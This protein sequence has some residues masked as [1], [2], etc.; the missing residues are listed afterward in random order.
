MLCVAIGCGDDLQGD[1]RQGGDA[2]IAD[3]TRDAFSTPI[4]GLAPEISAG[5]DRGR[6]VFRFVWAPPQLGRL[7]NHSS[8]SACHGGG[9]RGISSL[10]RGVLGSQAL[11]RVSLAE[12]TP[13]EPGGN[14]A[15]PDLGE[16]LQDH[17]TVGLPEVFLT[18]VWDETSTTYGDGDVE[19]MRV[20]RVNVSSPNGGAVPAM[21][22]SYRQGPAVFGLGLLDAV[23]DDTL[24]S[25]EDPDDHD[26][27]GISGRVNFVWDRERGEMRVGR[28][29][30]KATAAD[31]RHQ[32]AGAFANDLGLTNDLHPEPAGAGDVTSAQLADTVEFVSTLAVPAA[33]PRDPRALIGSG[34]FDRFGCAAC[35]T[36]TL[37]TGEHDIAALSHQRIHP[38]TDLLLHDLG[39]SLSD[40]R[41]D[42]AATGAEWR[43]PALW[44]IG[45]T[46]EVQ[47]GTTYL[48][49]GRARSLAEAI[50]WHGGE[51]ESAR[52]AFRT[53][54]KADRAAL[55]RFLETL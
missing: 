9:G 36:R 23:A 11:V 20:P 55:I 30:H 8:C 27:D 50:L 38:Y 48:H 34:L 45:L 44:G 43:T 21:L 40:G 16:Q 13:S 17:A 19:P 4:P 29:G 18:L 33:G 42:H 7:F 39:G 53:A 49:D 10:E 15:V 28:F 46:S 5:H 41:P 14:V 35:H 24:L 47:D 25:L 32:T 2:T 26:G 12:G 54:R 6:N 52:E 3:R 31:L 1:L 37:D 22:T 51:A